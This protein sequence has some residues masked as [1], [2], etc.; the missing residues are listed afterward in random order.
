MARIFISYR[1]QDS[2]IWVS[3][4]VEELRKHFPPD[5]VF[6]DVASIE[7]GADFVKSLDKALGTAAVM[8]AVIGP[9]WL[10]ATDK[11]GHRRLDLPGDFV[12]QEIAES[13]RRP[14]VRVFPLLV[15]GAQM[16]AEED[17]PEPLK[18]LAYRQAFELT[19]TLVIAE[20]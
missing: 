10:S 14:G 8:L 20:T 1:R 2:D 18:P 16:P 17:L 7:P 6:Q 19:R 15:N 13:L 4:L 11:Q 5:Q 12:R 9:G 3:R